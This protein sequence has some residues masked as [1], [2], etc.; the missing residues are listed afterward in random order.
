[1]NDKKKAANIYIRPTAPDWLR[2]LINNAIPDDDVCESSGCDDCG[3]CKM[4][5]DDNPSKAQLLT[6]Y[7]DRPVTQFKQYDAHL[8]ARD[9]YS[10]CEGDS[11]SQMTTYELLDGATVS[12]FINPREKK[13]DVL[14]GIFKLADYINRSWQDAQQA[15]ARQPGPDNYTS[16]IPF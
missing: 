4:P 9:G 5:H 16:D 13:S 12:V 1:M 8:N 11:L 14:R 15:D 2:D 6:K 7:I 10:D 3:Q